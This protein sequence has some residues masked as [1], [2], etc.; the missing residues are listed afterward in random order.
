MVTDID[1]E[2]RDL[3]DKG[4]HFVHSPKSLEGG[5]R[6]AHFQYHDE[7]MGNRQCL[8][9][10]TSMYKTVDHQLVKMFDVE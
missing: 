5:R 2:Y 7:T 10:N 1:A 4:V 6:T 3:L 9:G 8:I